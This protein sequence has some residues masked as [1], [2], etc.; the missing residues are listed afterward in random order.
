MDKLNNYRQLIKRLLKHY[1]NQLENTTIQDV[2]L[3]TVFDE[4]T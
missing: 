4:E 3:H 1:A 2:E